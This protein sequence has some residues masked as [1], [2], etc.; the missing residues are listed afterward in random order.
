M[1]RKELNE[2]KRWC[3]CYGWKIRTGYCCHQDSNDTLIKIGTN[4]GV[5]GWN[6]DAYIAPNAKILFIDGYRNF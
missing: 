5:Y 2:I 4:F 1:T 3:E 6:W